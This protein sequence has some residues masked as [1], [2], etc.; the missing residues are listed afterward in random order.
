MISVQQW[1]PDTIDLLQDCLDCTN[2]DM[3]IDSTSDLNE[4][5]DTI[6]EY[7]N[8][9]VD[10]CI[11]RKQVKAYPNNKPWITKEVKSII[12][13]KKAVFGRG[14][15]PELKFIDR[16]IRRE[17]ANYPDKIEDNFKENNMKKV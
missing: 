5:T 1:T 14:D 17:R 12:N 15:K 8:F 4:L 6:T 7:V 10:S 11:P 9:C 16:A 2:W 3:F 13:R